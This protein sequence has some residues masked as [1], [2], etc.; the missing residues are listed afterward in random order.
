MNK[1][2]HN[3]LKLNQIKLYLFISS[4]FISPLTKAEQPA[5]NGTV[6][7]LEK[8][9]PGLF[10]DMLGIRPI[11]TDNGFNYNLGYL[12]Q[13]AYNSGG[14]YDH[15][16][17]VAF[18]D[19]LALTFTQD[20]ERFTDIPDARIEGNIVN[21][22]HND[23]LTIKRIQDPRI[24][25]ND[26]SQESYGGQSITRLGW[27]TFARTF[28]DRR[29]T[30]RVGMMNKSQ[31]FD[32]IAPCDFQTLMLCG[33]KSS[34]SRTWSNWNVHTWGTTF[35]YQ[36]TPEVTL[37]WG[38]MEQN[39]K[40]STRN[41]A[42][43]WSTKGSKGVLLPFEIESRTH[44]LGLPGAYNLGILFTNATQV[45]L[46]SGKSENAGAT[47]PNGYKDYRRTW[48]M[49]GG[50]NQQITRHEDDPNRG[51][52]AAFNFSLADQRTVPRHSILAAALRYR[53]LFDA[54]PEDWIGIGISHVDV[55]KHYARNLAYQN[56]VNGVSD[57][58]DPLYLPVPSNSTNME[59]YYRYRPVTWL[60]LQPE[61]QYWHAPAG[62]KETQDA[63]V[64]ALKTYITF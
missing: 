39:P 38:V 19:Q 25:N 61:I 15:D 17:H 23:D 7:G 10:G 3:S 24:R 51:L 57:Y 9:Q 22:N 56:Q 16:K 58:N 34:S 42:W 20:L 33:G 48:F 6:L 52:S 45:D 36:A 64:L 8:T 62:V 44:I 43:S 11:L 21:R 40:A 5:W 30:W 53:G 27:L 13:S 35:S 28:D 47:D 14:G 63:V 29:L 4:L 60:E 55:S 12:T 1:E 49:W 59:L 50:M 41:H 2:Y 31:T 46:Y 54:R 26:L 37:K 18:I 32:K